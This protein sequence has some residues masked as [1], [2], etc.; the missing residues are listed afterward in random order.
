MEYDGD[1]RRADYQCDGL[2]EE[3][4]AIV[5]RVTLVTIYHKLKA[6]E[7][8]QNEICRRID[9]LAP[10]VGEVN[11]HKELLEEHIKFCAEHR[12]GMSN[13]ESLTDAYERGRKDVEEDAQKEAEERIK[14]AMFFWAKILIPAAGLL[15]GLLYYFGDRIIFNG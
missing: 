3:D 2:A 15:F 1:E 8:N 14:R 4:G 6:V 10:K 11:G 7:H 9:E 13:N 5:K 12:T